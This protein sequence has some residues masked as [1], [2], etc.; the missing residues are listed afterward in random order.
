MVNIDLVQFD[1]FNAIWDIASQTVTTKPFTLLES[2]PTI[3]PI[4]I[5]IG[6]GV[7]LGGVVT[8]LLSHLVG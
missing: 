5:L 3:Y 8:I 6:A 4:E 1:S 2:K 7:V